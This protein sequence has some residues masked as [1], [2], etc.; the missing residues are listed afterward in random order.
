MIQDI[1]QSVVI[2]PFLIY[3][4]QQFHG[5]CYEEYK[6]NNNRWNNTK[7]FLAVIAKGFY[8]NPDSRKC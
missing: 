5:K 7:L 3:Q 4:I 2:I 1:L 6:K 8:D